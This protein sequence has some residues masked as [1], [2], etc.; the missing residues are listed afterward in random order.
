MSP[1]GDYAKERKVLTAFQGKGRFILNGYNASMQPPEY[2][3][4]GPEIPTL[5]TLFLDGVQRLDP[6]SWNRLV[7]SFGPVVYRWCRISGVPEADAADIV[8][9]VFVAVAR[10]IATFERAKQQGSFRSWLA[11][12]TRN[13]VRDYFR[14]C[15]KQVAAKG[16]SEAVLRLNQLEEQLESTICADDA[17]V[18]VVREA[19]ERVRVEFEQTTWEAFW[20]ATIDGRPTA[21][22]AQQ[23]AISAASVYQAKSRVLR[24]LR[25]ELRDLP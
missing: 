24:R 16:G 9:E 10:G 18:M 12:I 22:I 23:L 15:S 13:K 19:L 6:A 4:A 7:T 14:R 5:S 17:Q 21:D 25:A 8:Q 2:S 20:M 1:G 3:S 11:T